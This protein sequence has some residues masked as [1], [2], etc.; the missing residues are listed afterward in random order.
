MPTDPV[1]ERVIAKLKER[2]AKGLSEYGA[3]LD[4]P[5]YS[6]RDWLLE[7]QS[8]LLDAANYIERLLQEDGDVLGH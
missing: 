4:R 2:S 3:G 8:E 5:D 6:W 1:V 7:L